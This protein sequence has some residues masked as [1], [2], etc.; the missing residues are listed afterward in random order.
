MNKRMDQLEPIWERFIGGLTP[1][2]FIETQSEDAHLSPTN[3]INWA[4]DRYVQSMAD[5]WPDIVNHSNELKEYINL[6]YDEM[7]ESDNLYCDE[8]GDE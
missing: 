7:E 3:L 8:R 1:E 6:Y 2:E 5:E 4:V